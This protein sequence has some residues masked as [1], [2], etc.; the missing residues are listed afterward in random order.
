MGLHRAVTN[1]VM[2]FTFEQLLVPN[3]TQVRDGPTLRMCGEAL[4]AV[5]RL[6][7]TRPRG[8]FSDEEVQSFVDNAK[9]A[10]SAFRTLGIKKPK[11]HQLAKMAYLCGENGSPGNWGCWAE[12]GLNRWLRRIANKAHR[13]VWHS[14]A[15]AKFTAAYGLGSRRT[16]PRWA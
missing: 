7:R 11:L 16:R 3:E 12:D 8:N 1:A 6:L 10:L 5:L 2:E 14:R 15:L 13:A 4:L 9:L